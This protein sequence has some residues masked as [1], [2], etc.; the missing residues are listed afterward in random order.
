MYRLAR[1]DGNGQIAAVEYPAH[2]FEACTVQAKP[3]GQGSQR[4][5]NRVHF[6]HAGG[7][8][9]AALLSL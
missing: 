4:R 3:E 1:L 8:F 2:G 9:L 7:H 6:G 5:S